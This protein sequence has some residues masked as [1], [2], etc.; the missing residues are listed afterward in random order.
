MKI[1]CLIHEP[2]EDSAAIGT[3]AQQSHYPLTNTLLYKNDTLPSLDSFDWLVVMG[4]TMN[5]YQYQEHPWLKIEKQYI[6]QALQA[7]K[8]IIGVCLGAQLIADVLGAPTT[9]NKNREI[10]WFPVTFT[11]QLRQ[12]P[13]FKHFPEKMEV[14]HW[15]GDTFQMPADAIPFGSSQATA[16][17]GFVYNSRV[18]GFQFH[19]EY[20]VE[21]IEMMLT[22]CAAEMTPGPHVQTPAQIR[23]DIYRRVTANLKLLYRFL[24][25][26]AA[27]QT[28]NHPTEI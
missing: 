15:H 17:Q 8:T 24:D 16:N 21:A 26:A 28:K 9:Q 23:T 7:G 3:W 1:H 11:P 6:K 14:F 4:G 10:G 2:F 22:H 19:M 27:T 5:I 18:F 13:Q 25:A 20:S 12:L